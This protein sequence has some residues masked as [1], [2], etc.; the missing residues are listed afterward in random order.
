MV[1]SK[2]LV[3]E[4]KRSRRMVVHF[5]TK[6]FTCGKRYEGVIANLSTYG[7]GVYIKIRHTEKK[8]DCNP[9]SKLDLVFQTDSGG[10][11]YLHCRVN[12]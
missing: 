10:A 4:K 2:G 6:L 7:I 8:I 3:A 1:Q 9:G 5:D 12:W 11:F